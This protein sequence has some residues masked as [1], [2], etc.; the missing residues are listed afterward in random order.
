MSASDA[1]ALALAMVRDYLD[2]A[3]YALVDFRLS[4]EM[5]PSPSGFPQFD[6]L[7]ALVDDLD[8][9]HRVLF[10]LLRL[11]ECVS[12]HE[13]ERLVG[14][15]M[16]SALRRA[17]LLVPAD[18][19][20]TWRTPSLLLVPAE[21]LLLLASTPES[22]PTAY[23]PR[24]TWFDMSAIAIARALPRSL[25]GA[26]V[27]DVGAG[28]GIQALLCASRGA[29]EV[30][31]LDISA[32][33]VA[34]AR[35]NAILNRQSR[36][37]EFRRSDVLAA[38]EGQERFDYVVCNTP[39]SP[40]LQD[41]R[42]PITPVELGNSVVWRLLET[43]PLHLTERAHGVIGL[44]RSVGY[45]GASYQL[46]AFA[47]RLDAHGYET[48]AYVDHAPDSREDVLRILRSELA[49]RAGACVAP[50]TRGA[51][52]TRAQLELAGIVEQL[53]DRSDL[54]M[55]GFYNQLVFIKPR[56]G[57]EISAQPPVFG[58]G[59]RSAAALPLP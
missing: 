51:P 9:L 47:A 33:A 58:L 6:A 20:G 40:A 18:H 30:V 12:N 35:A 50:D 54:P 19:A 26:R 16:I 45:Q 36:A 57:G 55:D 15:P 2:E 39:Y 8:P 13:L 27:L 38:L 42:P 21:G 48:H 59:I 17:E 34:V 32:R 25:S 52:E 53:L 14:K 56:E 46:D 7:R 1:S 22:Y 49:S 5:P 11:G 28:T 23:G 31:G 41:G 4:M 44:W 10:R 3:M 37:V 29:S 24:D 43:L